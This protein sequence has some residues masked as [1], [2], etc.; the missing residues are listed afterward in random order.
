MNMFLGK[1][2]FLVPGIEPVTFDVQSQCFLN[3]AILAAFFSILHIHYR[4]AKKRC[5]FTFLVKFSKN[6]NSFFKFSKNLHF[7]TTFYKNLLGITYS[8][9]PKNPTQMVNTTKGFC[10]ELENGM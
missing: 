3:C 8:K 9:R 10:L 1:N 5:F 2:I 6:T 7:R 4:V